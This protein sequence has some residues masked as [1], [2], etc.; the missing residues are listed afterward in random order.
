M[1]KHIEQILEAW[2]QTHD[3]H[4]EADQAISELNDLK[5]G[6]VVW[7][8]GTSITGSEALDLL[9][10]NFELERVIKECIVFGRKLEK[11]HPINSIT[12]NNV[13]KDLLAILSNIEDFWNKK[14]K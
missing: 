8:G 7:A 10:K 3:Q 4:G 11:S 9:R 6:K 12:L 2:K 1:T 13:G 14:E 5:N